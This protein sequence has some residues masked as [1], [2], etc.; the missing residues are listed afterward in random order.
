MMK[1]LFGITAASV[2]F[3]S[4]GKEDE[5]INPPMSDIPFIEIIS[6]TPSTVTALEDSIVFII[7]YED[8]NGDLGFNYPD[9]LSLYITDPRIPL[10]ESFFVPLL[11]PEGA[12]IAIQGE[13]EVTLNNTILVNPDADSE[14]VSFEISLRDRAGNLSNVAIAP[15]ITVLH[16]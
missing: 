9:S 3:W 8:G 10:T 11:A 14:T 16:E 5:V 4:C 1:L 2:L 13:L 6:A 12:D 7:H 15:A